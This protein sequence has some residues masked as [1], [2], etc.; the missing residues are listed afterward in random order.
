[1]GDYTDVL[2]RLVMY[3]KSLG[4]IQTELAEKVGIGQEQYSYI[5]NGSVKIS[6]HLLLEFMKVGFG[7]DELI[8]GRSYSYEADDLDRAINTIDTDE[9]KN[10]ALKLLA[11][12]IVNKSRQRR[13]HMNGETADNMEMLD[14]LSQSWN[15]FSMTQFV[16]TRLSLSQIEMAE[17]L[18]LGI[19]KYRELERETIYPDAETLLS[20]YNMSNYRPT[21]FMN[22][23]D[24]KIQII[25][26]IWCIFTPAEK[27]K[28]LNYAVASA[29]I[30]D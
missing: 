1:M 19:K 24:R 18:G 3:R 12:L 21:L 27:E 13:E 8:A 6:G 16:R 9:N 4:L 2:K 5:E 15:D 26:S 23:S 25:K 29:N 10:F 28:L 14:A 30:L 20:L 11:E 7:T 17:R 22:M